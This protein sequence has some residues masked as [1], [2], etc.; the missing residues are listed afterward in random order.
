M[1]KVS[2]YEGIKNSVKAS[3]STASEKV[4]ALYS[5]VCISHMVVNY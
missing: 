5:A 2:S 1:L 4:G 3:G